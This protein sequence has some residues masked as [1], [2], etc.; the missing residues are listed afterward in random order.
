M[1]VHHLLLAIT[2]LVLS[3]L[4]TAFAGSL[5]CNYCHRSV[6][7]GT[8]RATICLSCHGPGGTSVLRATSHANLDC[9]DCHLR[10]YPYGR[11]L[12]GENKK[13]VRP[14]VDRTGRH[15]DF[16]TYS[17]YGFPL[18][19]TPEKDRAPVVF[20]SRGTGAGE[21]SLHSFADGDEDGNGVYDG[22]CEV[23][24]YRFLYQF[25]EDQGGH[26]VGETCTDCHPHRNGF[27]RNAE[28]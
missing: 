8:L 24:H 3:L 22:I 10:H 27:A 26:H 9:L 14:N 12:E 19:V 1:R 5:S 11:E 25:R 13:G 15:S 21:P 6:S 2:F 20:E 16:E 28:Q 17:R 23:C 7:L 18:I 4:P